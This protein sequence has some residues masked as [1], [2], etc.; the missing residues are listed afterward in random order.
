MAFSARA[1]TSASHRR[2]KK[3]ERYCLRNSLCYIRLTCQPSTCSG[4]RHRRHRVRVT[5]NSG[6]DSR[7][8]R[9]K[10]K[11]RSCSPMSVKRSGWKLEQAPFIIFAEDFPKLTSLRSRGQP[12]PLVSRRGFVARAESA[13]VSTESGRSL[14]VTRVSLSLARD[15]ELVRASLTQL[16]LTCTY[17]TLSGA[18]L[19]QNIPRAPRNRQRSS[20]FSRRKE[21][22]AALSA[23]D[24]M[25]A[26]D[27][28]R[29]R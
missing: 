1:S 28:A 10:E 12:T 15:C 21:D 16:R 23:S 17:K 22:D 25:T 7:T 20:R 27:N 4:H 26:R 14:L 18:L 11:D 8:P 3:A 6:A 2:H 9:H 19:R 13:N 29:S 24:P 5:R